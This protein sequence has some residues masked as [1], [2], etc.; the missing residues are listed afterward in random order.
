MFLSPK[1]ERSNEPSYL[2]GSVFRID[3]DDVVLG[4]AKK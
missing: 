1:G 3:F 4:V 2:R